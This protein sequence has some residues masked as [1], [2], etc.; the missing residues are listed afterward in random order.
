MG[1]VRPATGPLVASV[2]VGR[3]QEVFWH[4]QTIRT[5]IWKQSV[6]GPVMLRGVNLVG[7]DQADR[8]VHGGEYKA[9]YAYSMEDYEFWATAG[10]FEVRPGLFGE[11]LTLQ[12]LDLSRAIIGERWRAGTALLQVTQPRLPCFKLGIRV[13][14]P[15]FPKC[16]Q[17]AL[18]PGAY[19]RIIEEGMIE[20]GDSVQV[21]MRP[22][23][24]ITI[25]FAAESV[26]DPAKARALL[27]AP[28]LPPSWRAIA[29]S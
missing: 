1:N 20:A 27:A 3:A 10:K 28:E 25:R 18:R 21:L 2:N 6:Q 23:H 12:G 19:L 16:F 9:V 15:K 17:L 4:G 14:D 11:N 7:D 29:R 22:D 26:R 5:A 13:G 8:S 24:Q